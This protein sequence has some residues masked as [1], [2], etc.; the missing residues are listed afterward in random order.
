M[1]A[2]VNDKIRNHPVVCEEFD[3]AKGPLQI[4]ILAL[5]L[6]LASAVPLAAQGTPITVGPL[7]VTVPPGWTGQVNIV[8][9]RVFAPGSTP[10]HFFSVEFFPPDPRPQALAEHHGQ[11]WG[12]IAST[13]HI[14]TPPQSGMSG[15]FVWTRSDVPRAFGR[16]ETFILYSAGT[17]SAFVDVAVQAT[18]ADLVS[19]H[20]PV[21]ETMLRNAVLSDDGSVPSASVPGRA[22]GSGSNVSAAAGTPVSL[23]DYVYQT[24]A[25]WNANQYSDGIVLTSP[26]SETG[27]RCLISMWPMRPTSGNLLRDADLAFRDIYKTYVLKS[28]TSSGMIQSSLIRGTSGQGWDYVMIKRGIAKPGG[29]YETLLGFVLAAKLDS[30]VAIV[31]GISKEPLISACMGELRSA[32]V[33]PKFLYSLGFKSWIPADQTAALRRKLAGTWTA[34][35]AT[36]ADQFTFAGNGRYASAAAAQQYRLLSSSELLTT[37]QAYFGNG[38]YTLKGSALTLLQ[39]DK[40]SQPENAFF[41]IEEES[42]DDGRSW[43]ESLYLLRTSAIDG[44]PYELRYTKR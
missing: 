30:R 1:P 44:Q 41:R 31:S 24:P 3:M 2:C 16:K 32:T 40:K 27:E 11:I 18:H 42:K 9:V 7:T 35:T 43:V 10:Q 38:S 19:R 36:A 28:Q 39:D 6:I 29:Q 22:V 33:W 12:R 23:G 17:G 15:R 5:C 13:F 37:T 20:L 25:G 34:A 4:L 21:L 8:P 14:T 26:V